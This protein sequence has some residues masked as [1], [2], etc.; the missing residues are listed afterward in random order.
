MGKSKKPLAIFQ[1]GKQ[2]LTENF[3]QTLKIAFSSRERV[4]IIVLKAAGHTKENATEIAEKIVKEL[5][6]HYTFKIVG[7]TIFLQ[8]WRKSRK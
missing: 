6:S 8:K 1:I 4:K 7:F 3:M 2:G 5:G